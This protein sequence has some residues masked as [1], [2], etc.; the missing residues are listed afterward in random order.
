[1]WRGWAAWAAS[2]AWTSGYPVSINGQPR[3]GRQLAVGQGSQKVDN[4]CAIGGVIAKRIA[5][6]RGGLVRSSFVLGP[7]GVGFLLLLG[8]HERIQ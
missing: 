1:M 4:R 5:R 6:R 3:E 7:V 2:A 8:V